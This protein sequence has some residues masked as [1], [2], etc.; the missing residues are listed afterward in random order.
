MIEVMSTAAKTIA[1][2]VFLALLG[3]LLTIPLRENEP[4]DPKR[5]AASPRPEPSPSPTKRR[6]EPTGPLRSRR[7]VQRYPKACL[8]TAP[9]PEGAGLVAVHNGRRVVM[10]DTNGTRTATI[11]PVPRIQPPIAW[12]PSG[13]YIAIGHQGL[14]WTNE[15]EIVLFANG[16]FS[17][18]MVQGSTGKWAWSPIADCG[19]A[20]ED[21]FVGALQVSHIDP[22]LAAGVRLVN[23]G[24]ES[25]AFSRDGRRLGLVLKEGR[26]RSLWIAHLEQSRMVEVRRFVRHT[27]CIELAG[28]SPDDRDLLYWA[29]SGASVMAD[30]WPLEGVN[31]W[32]KVFRY[33]PRTSSGGFG[34]PNGI[35]TE[36]AWLVNCGGRLLAPLGG[37]RFPSSGRLISFL[38]RDK[39]PIRVSS[40]NFADVDPTCSPNGELIVVAR[41]PARGN[42]NLRR[43]PQKELYLM[44]ASDARNADALRPI[45][46]EGGPSEGSPEWGPPRTGILYTSR[47]RSRVSFWFLP[48]GPAQRRPLGI[49]LRLT[50][51]GFGIRDD[52]FDWSATPPDGLPAG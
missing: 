23:R 43:P 22:H 47:D 48:E 1:A 27:C 39:R 15:G 28:W 34:L 32:G 8:R 3:G 29:G 44:S 52:A 16:E 18:G 36:P 46:E 35:F 49:S 2:L 40:G 12:S 26:V 14:F 38:R 51:G 5:V 19:V 33:T 10:A 24:V 6:R 25:F 41:S 7:L 21:D 9:S 13:R 30:G 11:R 45:T 20:I 37:D 17:H 42:A 31:A 4:R 50:E